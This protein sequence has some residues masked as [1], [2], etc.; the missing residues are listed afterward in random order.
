MNFK[1]G[2]KIIF[3]IN[4]QCGFHCQSRRQQKRNNAVEPYK[5]K[6]NCYKQ[7]KHFFSEYTQTSLCI[8]RLSFGSIS[9]DTWKKCVQ[10]QMVQLF[11]GSPNPSICN[12]LFKSKIDDLEPLPPLMCSMFIIL[13]IFSIMRITKPHST[14]FLNQN[15]LL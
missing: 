4:K 6:K 2:I 15:K 14:F 9:L 8:L 7:G 5:K 11:S 12:R 1:L 3:F 10:R 13:I